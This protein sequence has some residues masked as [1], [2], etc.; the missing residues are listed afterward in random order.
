MALRT[1]NLMLPHDGAVANVSVDSLGSDEP[2]RRKDGL[3]FKLVEPL[4]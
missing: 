4:H 1:M 2:R 3:G